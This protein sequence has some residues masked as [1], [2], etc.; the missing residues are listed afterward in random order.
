MMTYVIQNQHGH[1]LGKNKE[2]TDGRDRRIVFRCQDKVDAIN[3]V[4]ELSSKDIELRA[5]YREC[6]V[7][8]FGNPLVEASATPLSISAK[9]DESEMLEA[10]HNNPHISA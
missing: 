6:D 8:D 10:S 5:H 9:A 4:F 3:M 7:D 2:W 1:Y